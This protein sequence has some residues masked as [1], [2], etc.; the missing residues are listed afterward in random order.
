MFVFVQTSPVIK[1]RGSKADLDTLNC[2]YETPLMVEVVNSAIF[3]RAHE[4]TTTEK[5]PMV[6]NMW[7]TSEIY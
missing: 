1:H 4:L 7:H 5:R 6:T 3:A 2:F